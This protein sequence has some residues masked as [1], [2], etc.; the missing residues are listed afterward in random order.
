MQAER[1]ELQETNLYHRRRIEM[2]RPAKR[3]SGCVDPFIFDL[4]Q[5]EICLIVRLI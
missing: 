5:A 4:I 1:Q 3:Q 2:N